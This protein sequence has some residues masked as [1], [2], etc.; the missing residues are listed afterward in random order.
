MTKYPR[1]ELPQIEALRSSV[2][3]NPE[4][5]LLFWKQSNGKPKRW[6]TRYAGKPAFACPS[7]SG[8]LHGNFE[9]KTYSAHKVAWA[10]FYGEWPSG[11][12]DHADR[13]RK[14]NRISN[15]RIATPSDNARNV[16]SHG[17]SRFL[18]VYWNKKDK[19]WQAQ[20]WIDGRRRNLGQFLDE[21]TAAKSYDA[22]ARTAHGD[23]AN[24]NFG[25]QG[26]ESSA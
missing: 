4:T 8:Y 5:G 10:I 25:I 19:R 14:N 23:F 7:S 21:E 15:L 12:M 1:S 6:N 2:L 11:W 18:G 3:Y 16:S 22:A 9:G 24:L 13:D 17:R 26:S 20:I